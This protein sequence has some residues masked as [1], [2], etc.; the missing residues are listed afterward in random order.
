MDRLVIDRSKWLTGN[1]LKQAN[2]LFTQTRIKP[3][4]FNSQMDSIELCRK[5]CLGFFLEEHIP[6]GDIFSNIPTPV[7]YVTSNY[8]EFDPDADN[9][10]QRRLNMLMLKY[11]EDQNG[12]QYKHTSIGSDLMAI[13]DDTKKDDEK[14]E[15]DIADKFLELGFEVEFIGEYNYADTIALIQS[16]K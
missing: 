5:C 6:D 12:S 7:G 1:I 3:K 15:I 11:G 9:E 13:N 10:L 2:A 14:R 16:A 4:E 8:Y